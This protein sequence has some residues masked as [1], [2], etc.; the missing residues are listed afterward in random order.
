MFDKKKYFFIHLF[1]YKVLIFD[2]TK[3]KNKIFPFI[4]DLVLD[5]I[6]KYSVVFNSIFVKN[7]TNLFIYI[8]FLYDS[9]NKTL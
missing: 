2:L 8:C 3:N 4:I 7:F 1:S 5:D 6:I 9:E